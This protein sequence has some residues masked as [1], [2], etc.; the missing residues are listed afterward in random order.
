MIRTRSVFAVISA[1]VV[2]A[3]PAPALETSL[4]GKSTLSPEVLWQTFGDFCGMTKWHPLVDEC[5]LSGEGKVRTLSLFGGGTVVDVLENWDAANHTYAYTSASP[6]PVANCRAK[7]NVI[8]DGRGS[9][10]QLTA[11]FEAKGISDADAKKAVDRSVFRALCV[12]APLR[13]S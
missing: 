13:C 10:L 7:V 6:L 3:I 4:T 2:S 5:V 11:T 8:A 12:S 9:T 1:L